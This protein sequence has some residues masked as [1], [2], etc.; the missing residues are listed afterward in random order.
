MHL[1]HVC[2]CVRTSHFVTEFFAAL[3]STMHL[4]IRNGTMQCSFMCLVH[5]FSQNLISRSLSCML[6]WN[7]ELDST[8]ITTPARPRH[9]SYLS[10]AVTG[11]VLSA[12]H[13]VLSSIKYFSTTLHSCSLT[14]SPLIFLGCVHLSRSARVMRWF[15]STLRVERPL[16]IYGNS[17]PKALHNS[18][19]FLQL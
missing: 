1:M 6:G 10:G 11:S 19:N 8:Y 13:V 18:D 17:E 2:V 14:S 16:S 4:F 5:R 7:D 3:S 9:T 15:S 12:F